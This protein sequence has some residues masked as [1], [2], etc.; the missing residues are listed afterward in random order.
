MFTHLGEQIRGN[1]SFAL[2]RSAKGRASVKCSWSVLPV[3]LFWELQKASDWGGSLWWALSLAL[4]NA[5]YTHTCMWLHHTI[6]LQYSPISVQE[7]GFINPNLTK[8]EMQLPPAPIGLLCELSPA[9]LILIIGC[10]YS[11]QMSH[12]RGNEWLS[13]VWFR[14]PETQTNIKTQTKI[15]ILNCSCILI[16]HHWLVKLFVFD[17][18]VIYHSAFELLYKCE[19]ICTIQYRFQLQD[20]V[21]FSQ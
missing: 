15:L 5:M 7:I 16:N 9:K 13:L 21:K 11:E 12:G 10:N 18:T 14:S 3:F 17:I 4:W 2:I 19:R 8:A 20:S 6:E 1:F